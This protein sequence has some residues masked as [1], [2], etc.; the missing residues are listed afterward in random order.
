[1]R[2]WCAWCGH[3]II[4]DTYID[5]QDGFQIAYPC[6]H[7]QDTYGL[8]PLTFDKARSYLIVNQVIGPYARG[9]DVRSR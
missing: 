8:F 5:W 9:A 1:M 3:K 4:V 6:N 7:C 2:Q